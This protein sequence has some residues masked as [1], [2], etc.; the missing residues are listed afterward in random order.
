MVDGAPTDADIIARARSE[1]GRFATV[2]DRHYDAI[3]R[4]LWTRVG[5]RAEDLTSEVFKVAF[6]QRDRYDTSFP[7]A[8]PWLFG[9]AARLAKQ[10]HREEAKADEIVERI[11]TEG[12]SDI[13]PEQRL[14]ELA[15][16][17]PVATALMR[18]PA[19]D[20]EP[21]LLHVWDDLSYEE[22]AQV[23]DVPL[24][25]VRSRI[26]RARRDLRSW[27]TPGDD[28]LDPPTRA[29]RELRDGRDHDAPT[30]G[31]ATHG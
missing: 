5:R 14:D 8:K 9:I 29:D 27:L 6:Q 28:H 16:S 1:P 11:G 13:S 4:F 7:S 21:L 15:P 26:H 25:T 3:H 19:R 31:G 17:S 30:E 12:A 20:R 23:L 18:L 22:V 10:Q 24:G 2:F